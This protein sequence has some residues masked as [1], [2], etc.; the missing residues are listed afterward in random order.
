MEKVVKCEKYS[1][2]LESPSVGEFLNLRSKIGWGELDFH[3]ASAQVFAPYIA[4]ANQLCCR[5]TVVSIL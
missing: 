5:K 2:N 3:L 1:L 4:L